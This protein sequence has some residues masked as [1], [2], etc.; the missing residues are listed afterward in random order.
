MEARVIFTNQLKEKTMSKLT[1][2]RKGE[3]RVERLMDAELNGAL[4]KVTKRVD[5]GHL[6][7]IENSQDAHRWV[8]NAIKRGI[9][10]E[11][12]A[13]YK[14]GRAVY[15]FHA[16]NPASKSVKVAKPIVIPVTE[17]VITNVEETTTQVLNEGVTVTLSTK[18][19][20]VEIKNATAEYV[21]ALING[22][23]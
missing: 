2:R 14:N 22:L 8:H 4:Q 21:V 10:T 6:V 16:V 5:V 20:N 23:K 18:N 3:L 9:L 1:R 17:P 12:I 7:G 19:I 13:G 15:E 11:T